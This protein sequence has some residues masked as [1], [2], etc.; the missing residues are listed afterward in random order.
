M[1]KYEPIYLTGYTEYL[2]KHKVS[3]SEWN[4]LFSALITG[5]NHQEDILKDLYN[6]KLKDVD[7]ALSSTST[8]PVQNKV[9]NARF[10]ELSDA[11]NAVGVR[12]S[13]LEQNKQP[14]L[15]Q[16]D[17]IT[18]VD[19]VISASI[20]K[21]YADLTDKPTIN[22][23]TLEGDLIIS[24]VT[25]TD[26]NKLNKLT[27]EGDANTFLNGTGDYIRIEANTSYDNLVKLSNLKIND[28][29]YTVDTSS[30]YEHNI[31]FI[32]P[33]YKDLNVQFSV[34]NQSSSAAK[35]LD[36][37]EDY[38]YSLSYAA[39]GTYDSKQITSVSLAENS[40]KI[41]T[42]DGAT[43]SIYTSH[44][45]LVI[46]YTILEE[47]IKGRY[48]W[49]IAGEYRLIVPYGESS[50]LGELTKAS[51]KQL[52][53]LYDDKPEQIW[54]LITPQN[55][56]EYVTALTKGLDNVENQ[57]IIYLSYVND[58]TIRCNL[59]VTNISNEKAYIELRP[60]DIKDIVTRTTDIPVDST[61]TK[62]GMPADAKAVGDKLNKIKID[63]EGNLFL[64]D[65][66]EYKLVHN[67]TNVEANTE[68]ASTDELSSITIGDKVYAMPR[69]ISLTKPNH[70][71]SGNIGEVYLDRDTKYL[72]Q[73]RK[74]LNGTPTWSNL[75]GTNNI[76]GRY[77]LMYSTTTVAPQLMINSATKYNIDGNDS[78]IPYYRSGYPL[79]ITI[80]NYKYAVKKAL[81]EPEAFNNSTATKIIHNSW[82]PEEQALARSTLGITNAGNIG[83]GLTL[84]KH[85]VSFEVPNVN[86]PPDIY[87]GYFYS[88]SSKLV[89]KTVNPQG[90]TFFPRISVT[91]FIGNFY[92]FKNAGICDPL[93][94]PDSEGYVVIY[95]KLD[96]ENF[97]ETVPEV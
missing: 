90:D 34:K 15:S 14:K 64:A 1:D 38:N 4:A 28:T 45:R 11:I 10:T 79:P 70:T 87:Y 77:G 35:N 29:V 41:T 78:G 19:N 40:L 52:L 84:Y 51:L 7:A 37:F 18:I 63:G 75:I 9:V 36:E 27:L 22:G 31:T 24:E 32:D 67:G 48:P 89:I 95:G 54:T 5:H 86:D 55:K 68:A 94:T 49:D 43:E 69:E 66:G 59:G 81:T 83:G 71:H 50:G 60:L 73:V 74:D 97:S 65:D 46:H 61:L 82:S 6:N 96:Y 93:P 20:L 26:R 8:N 44:R 85:I 42:I 21:S 47:S 91:D 76:T 33:V 57:Y 88:T 53:S 56:V 92:L 25:E 39:T 12:T 3:A 62:S 30:Y 13:S 80:L 23:N 72:S 58:P 16:G 17:N 2:S